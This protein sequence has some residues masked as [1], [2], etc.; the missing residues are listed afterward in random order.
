MWFNLYCRNEEK[1][2]KMKNNKQ[3]SMYINYNKIR[4]LKNCDWVLFCLISI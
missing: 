2:F 1:S 3:F 4:E